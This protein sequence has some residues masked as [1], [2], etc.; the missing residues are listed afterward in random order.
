MFDVDPIKQSGDA[1]LFDPGKRFACRAVHSAPENSC[2]VQVYKSH[3]AFGIV[4]YKLETDAKIH[5]L[6]YN[7]FFLAAVINCF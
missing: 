2:Q 3:K 5:L 6:I 1:T 7:G 4:G